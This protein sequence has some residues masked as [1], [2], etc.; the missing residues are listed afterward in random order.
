MPKIGDWVIYLD[1]LCQIIDIIKRGYGPW[2]YDLKT[3]KG[4]IFFTVE[5]C[6]IDF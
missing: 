6:F 5:E 1:E 2:Y 4:A 3:E